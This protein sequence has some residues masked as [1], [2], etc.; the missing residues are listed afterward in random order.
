MKICNMKNLNI[1]SLLDQLKNINFDTFNRRPFW[2]ALIGGFAMAFFQ[3]TGIAADFISPFADD[4]TVVEAADPITPKLQAK[5]NTITLSRKIGTTQPEVDARAY[6]VVDMDTHE[7]IA[8]KK[9]EVPTPVAS[10]TKVLSAV[11][12]LD[13]ADVTERFTVS[14]H[15]AS[16]IPTKIGVVPGEEMTLSELIQAMLLT[17][18]N[19]ATEVIKEGINTKYNED[20]F[21][22][23]MNTKA[24]FIGMNNSHFVNPQGFDN[25]EHYSSAYDLALLSLYAI[26]NYP[27][28][29]EVAQQDY[30]FL[31][32]NDSH[33]QFDLYNWNGLIGVYPNTFGL[34]TGMTERAGNT[35]IVMAERDGKKMLAVLLGA[36]S[37]I[38]RDLQAAA[39]L[40][41]GF[42]SA[43]ITPFAVDE[44]MLQKRYGRWEFWN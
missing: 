23:A 27:E 44:T 13:L 14:E 26:Q 39:L 33:K 1:Q 8:E 20:I 12:A 9:S 22:H 6:I 3:N 38:D 10:L 5:E 18:A 43:A 36:S 42:A 40:N 16:I 11:V 2:I 7:I 17:S 37:I 25:R 41:A 4:K 34:K 29:K 15:A 21:I 24:R 28:I 35:T 30:A 32:K 19:D 31:P